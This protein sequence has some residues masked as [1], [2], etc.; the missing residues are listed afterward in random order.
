MED[1]AVF[2][3]SLYFFKNC[4]LVGIRSVRVETFV[5]QQGKTWIWA[6]V[7]APC[8][9][10]CRH[11]TSIPSCSITVY[12]I[13]TF[14]MLVVI[15]QHTIALPQWLLL[16][17]WPCDLISVRCQRWAVLPNPWLWVWTVDFIQSGED[18][19][20]ATPQRRHHYII[21][22]RTGFDQF[23]SHSLTC[24]DGVGI[25]PCSPW[26]M[27]TFVAGQTEPWVWTWVRKDFFFFPLDVWQAIAFLLKLFVAMEASRSR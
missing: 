26:H 15:L 16:S 17:F 13:P 27:E 19:V 21:C 12:V 14:F 9:V 18:L 22:Q 6:A 5:A 8:P 23:C 11:A 24:S 20:T 3:F 4:L 10:F 7:G 2:V 1:E 25:V